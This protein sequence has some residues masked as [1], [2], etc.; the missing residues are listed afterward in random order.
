MQ[1]L[2]AVM[3]WRDRVIFMMAEASNLSGFQRPVPNVAV[4]S[5]TSVISIRTFPWYDWTFVL[6]A[7]F[8]GAHPDPV[9]SDLDIFGTICNIPFLFNLASI[10]SDVCS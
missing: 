4:G 5:S 1:D 7:L 3:T 2:G 10:D 9:L 8:L 6:A